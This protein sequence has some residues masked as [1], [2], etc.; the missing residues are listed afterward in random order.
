MKK[1]SEKKYS[2][3]EICNMIGCDL[4]TISKHI[5]LLKKSGLVV[6]DKQGTT[7]YYSIKVPCIMNIFDCVD[8]VVIENAKEKLNF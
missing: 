4:S 8:R 2:V 7:V 3:N 1:I 5:N 6:S